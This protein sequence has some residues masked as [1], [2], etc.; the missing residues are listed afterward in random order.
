VF[1]NRERERGERERE[2]E[3]EREASIH[4]LFY[5]C[6][7]I[8]LKTGMHAIPSPPLN[9]ERIDELAS[10]VGEDKAVTLYPLCATQLFPPPT[11]F[12][13]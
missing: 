6:M 13:K 12:H 11:A 4:L 7:Q 10:G 2:R 3:R 1:V 5:A 8:S 9:C